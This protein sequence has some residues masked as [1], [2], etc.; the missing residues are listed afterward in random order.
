[1]N[2]FWLPIMRIID[3]FPDWNLDSGE[4]TEKLYNLKQKYIR[5]V[6]AAYKTIQN[7]ETIEKKFNNTYSNKHFNSDSEHYKAFIDY[8]EFQLEE[9]KPQPSKK[10][11]VIV[12]KNISLKVKGTTQVEDSSVPKKISSMKMKIFLHFL[13]KSSIFVLFFIAPILL[14]LLITIV[15]FNYNYTVLL[16]YQPEL[17]F[18]LIFVMVIVGIIS[19]WISILITKR[20]QDNRRDSREYLKLKSEF[21]EIVP[22]S[23]FEDRKDGKT[24][25]QW[26]QQF[27]KF[28]ESKK[29]DNR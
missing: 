1:V 14:L 7:I 8:I 12:E 5:E 21:N 22:L 19:G 3:K 13:L 18:L 9:E 4:E 11:K 27:E 2:R 17:F 20:Y 15:F 10:I 28:L 26:Y 25:T 24:V 29:K 16:Q 23:I 6:H